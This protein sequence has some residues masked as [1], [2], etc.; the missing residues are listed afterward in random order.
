[1][2]GYG[3]LRFIGKGDLPAL[4]DFARP[5]WMHTFL[6]LMDRHS[7]E[8]VFGS[9]VSVEH[10]SSLMDEGYLM[11]YIR[12]GDRDVGWFSF[13]VQDDRRVLIS[14]LY[15]LPECQRHGIGSRTLGEIMDYARGHGADYAYLYVFRG[16]VN[17]QKVYVANGFIEIR[18]EYE[19]LTEDVVRDDIVYGRPL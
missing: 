13:H 6:P 11:G 4:V 19:K 3:H 15:L 18:R 10:L 5:I 17:A 1:M 12:D 9:W 16:N 14:K 7:A 8:Y 2:E